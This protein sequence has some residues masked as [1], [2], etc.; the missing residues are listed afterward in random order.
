MGGWGKLKYPKPQHRFWLKVWPRGDCWEWKGAIG[1][2]GYG[3]FD[4]FIEPTQSH[5]HA[6]ELA[7]Q[8]TIPRNLE[9]DHLCSHRWCMRPSHMRLATR[10]ENGARGMLVRRT[11]ERWAGPSCG[12][13]NHLITKG[14]NGKN[15]LYCPECGRINRRRS[16][17]NTRLR[18]IN[19]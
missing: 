17:E 13:R 10:E 1:P 5:R 7:Y 12:D 11:K 15:G 3:R 6:F 14:R 8:I 4:W 2:A 9:I 16:A 19:P 18:A